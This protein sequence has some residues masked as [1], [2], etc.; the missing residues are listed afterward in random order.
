M[1]I[2]E[3]IKGEEIVRVEPSKPLQ[4]VFGVSTRDRSYL[5]DRLIFKGIANGNIYLQRTG[6]SD[7][8]FRGELLDLPLDVWS[9]GWEHWI[10]PEDIETD[11]CPIGYLESA[12][13]NAADKEDYELAE[14]LKVI[15]DQLKSVK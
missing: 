10:D 8:I 7:R 5:G 9:E 11:S 3:F 13:L 4:N 12:M 15:I 1:T 14:K 2:F 6:I